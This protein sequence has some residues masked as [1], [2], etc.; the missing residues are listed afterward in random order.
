[1]SRKLLLSYINSKP[2]SNVTLSAN[3]TKLGKPH[4]VNTTGVFVAQLYATSTDAGF[5]V[6]RATSQ[7]VSAFVNADTA[8]LMLDDSATLH[9]REGGG[10]P[11]RTV[12]TGIA[13]AMQKV[14]MPLVRR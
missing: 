12:P 14:F 13:L 5:Y 11:T 8:T 6:I 7:T 9:P 3:E 10:T 2:G 4:L 1:M